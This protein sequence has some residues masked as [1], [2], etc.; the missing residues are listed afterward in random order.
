M[1]AASA[2]AQS[3]SWD[4]AGSD[5]ERYIKHIESAKGK[6]RLAYLLRRKD[7]E[8]KKGRALPPHYDCSLND[9]CSEK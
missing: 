5:F 8:E 9:I 1:A 6:G 3:D 4:W 7:S 2:P